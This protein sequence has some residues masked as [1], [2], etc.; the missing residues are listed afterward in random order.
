M[1]EV[2]LKARIKD[3]EGGNYPRDIRFVY[4]SEEPF[5]VRM[6][7]P[8]TDL[9]GIVV[10]ELD[11]EMLYKAATAAIATP[12]VGEGDVKI[13]ATATR[14]MLFLHG[15]GAQAGEVATLIFDR[16]AL[17]R[18]ILKVRDVVPPGEEYRHYSIDGVIARLLGRPAPTAQ[19]T[20]GE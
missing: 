17:R 13:A 18:F 15:S 7:I 11:R 2:T 5:V 9:G 6:E 14:L 4:R 3:T 8:G 1:I 10:W 20:E 12:P 19:P 16:P